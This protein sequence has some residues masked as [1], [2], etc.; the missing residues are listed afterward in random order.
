MIPA[1][2]I[3]QYSPEWLAAKLL[4]GDR[5]VVHK[6]S[7][8]SDKAEVKTFLTE[9]RGGSLYTSDCKFAWIETLLSGVVTRSKKTSQ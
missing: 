1:S 6:V 4:E 3:D 8:V 2:G 5:V 9:N 7:A